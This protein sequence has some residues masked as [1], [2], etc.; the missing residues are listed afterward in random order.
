MNKLKTLSIILATLTLM[1]AC[2]DS[3]KGKLD[4]RILD[5]WHAKINKDYKTAYQFLSPGWRK[6]EDELSYIRR[7]QVSK[8][9]W[10]GVKLSQKKCTQSDACQV[11]IIIDYEYQMKGSFSKN[12]KMSTELKEN[13]IMKNNIWFNVPLETKLK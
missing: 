10:T 6:N 3:E 12:M 13:W 1:T 11:T 2:I 8:V 7:L 4:N 9:K 5:F